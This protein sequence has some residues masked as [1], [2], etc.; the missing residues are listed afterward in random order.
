MTWSEF[1]PQSKADW[2]EAA[3]KMLKGKSME[4]FLKWRSRSGFSVDSYCDRSDASKKDTVNTRLGGNSW[5]IRERFSGP[6][7][8][9]NKAILSA[10]S[11]GV[12]GI[13]CD[14]TGIHPNE[15]PVLFKDVLTE[16][17]DVRLEVQSDPEAWLKAYIDWN[18]SRALPVKGLK[19]AILCDGLSTADLTAAAALA[20]EKEALVRLAHADLSQLR[21]KGASAALEL[22]V[23]L[24]KGHELL[25]DLMNSGISVDD[26]SALIEFS[27]ST[28]PDY[29][30]EIAKYKVFRSLWKAVVEAYSP[31]HSCSVETYVH[32]ENS[33]LQY[34]VNDSHNNLLRASLQAMAAVIGGVNAQL[35]QPFDIKETDTHR[36]GKRWAR[37]IQFVLR[38]ESFF[39]K[40]ADPSEGSWFLNELSEKLADKAWEQFQE[41]EAAGGY[42][43]YLSSGALEQKI[44]SDA[45]KWKEELISGYRTWIGVNKYPPSLKKERKQMKDN[46]EMAEL[47]W[48]LLKAK[49]E[50]A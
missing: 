8:E 31:E 25:V 1:G 14:C 4:E 29:L 3:I 34:S 36:Y 35:L 50:N 2:E 28:G 24:S 40:V 5:V 12:D 47:E 19:A 9:Q 13:V 30:E 20:V 32:A 46:S 15:L 41:I 43:G 16:I 42:S 33:V 27:L 37:N 38:D 23:A 22:G 44:N 17:L 10:L 49:E 21:N 7:K 39:D 26:A 48:E 6:A 11:E 18:T 45:Q